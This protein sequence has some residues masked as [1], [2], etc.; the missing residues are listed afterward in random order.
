[1]LR[2]R[3]FKY[4]HLSKYIVKYNFNALQNLPEFL[5]DKSHTNIILYSLV[6]KT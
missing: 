1:M 6:I 5:D 2:S 3:F 4:Q